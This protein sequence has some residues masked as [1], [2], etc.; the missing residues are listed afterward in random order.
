VAGD[1]DLLDLL[2]IDLQRH[3]A[4]GHHG[5]ALDVAALAGDPDHVAGLDAFLSASFSDSSMNCS[6]WT[7]AFRRECLVQWRNIS[8]ME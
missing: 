8:V 1:A 5:L 6:G 3:H 7:M 2:A 4:L